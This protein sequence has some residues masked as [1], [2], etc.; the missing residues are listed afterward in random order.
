MTSS[1]PSAKSSLSAF[2]KWA[3]GSSFLHYVAIVL[4]FATIATAYFLP[5][6]WE[7]RKLFQ[8]DVAGA[9]GNGSDVR[10]SGESSYWTN[11][12]FSGMPMYQISPSYPTSDKMQS[13]MD[14]ITLR[15]L[16]VMGAYAWLLFSMMVGF[17]LFLLSLGVKK[18]YATIGAVMWAFSSYFVILIAAGHIWKLMALCFIP[19]TIAGMIWIYRG[20]YIKGF[21]VMAFFTG[22][23]ILSNHVQMSYYFLFVM[24]A[25]VISFL[26]QAIRDKKLRQFFVASM[27]AFVAGVVGVAINASNLYHTY[28]YSKYTMRGGSELTLPSPVQDPTAQKAEEINPNGLSK[29][30]I[31]QWSYGIGETWSLAIP[32]VKGGASGVMGQNHPDQWAKAS[33]DSKQTLYGMPSYWGDQPF[34][35]GPVYVGAFVFFLFVLSIFLLQSPFKWP[36]L[37]VTLLSILLSWGHN[38]MWLTELFIDYI[39]MYDKF[40]AVSSILVIAEFTIPAL[41]ILMLLQWQK[42]PEQIWQKK[43]LIVMGSVGGLF[44]L[45]AAFPSLFFSFTSKQESE[46]FLQALQQQ[47]EYAPLI[48]ALKTLRISIFRADL[49]RSVALILIS[50]AFVWLFYKKKISSSVMWIVIGA[51][52][53]VDLWSVDKRYLHDDMFIANHEIEAM[54]APQTDA[55]REILQDKTLG[56]RVLNLSVNTFNDATTSRWHRSVGGYHA[57]KLQRYQDLI[58]HQLTKL[59]PRVINMLNT[60][61][62]ITPNEKGVPQAVLNQEAFGAAWFAQ[63]ISVVE[64]ANQEMLALDSTDLRTTA[65]VEKGFASSLAS[66]P[67]IADSTSFIRLVSYK[68]QEVIYQTQN[69][70][71][72]LAV[73]SEI[74]YPE[75][76]KMTIDGAEAP[77]LRANYVLRAARIPQ[78]EHTIKF[79]FAPES[80]KYTEQISK[81]ALFLCLG[82]LLAFLVTALIEGRKKK[83][84]Q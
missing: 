10:A 47:P 46:Y 21:L 60:R 16:P 3:H 33:W 2:Q 58:D 74:Y 7:G 23:Q 42:A 29:D 84:E 61:Y 73:F 25:F 76:W 6:S 53:L 54:A 24:L 18:W 30:Y 69:S 45:F 36:L 13:L 83:S 15:H 5:A 67:T 31:T 71:D 59:N 78:G 62:V 80:M 49:L 1:N 48:E 77:I 8:Q 19:P 56:Y 28:T 52:A 79:V 40:R 57:A 11:S 63:Q 17:F 81:Y 26:V 22:W 14:I 39:P 66:L 72:A 34:T 51:I 4:L 9:S 65:V 43:S 70:Q 75:G 35:A 50:L 27:V 12:L 37:G 44:L 68:P 38:F 55:D 20:S 41:A 82:G 64:G 32:N